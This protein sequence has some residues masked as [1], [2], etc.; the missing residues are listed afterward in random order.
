MLSKN[1]GFG[2]SPKRDKD[3]SL[4]TS[5]EREFQPYLEAR[6]PSQSYDFESFIKDRH[7][8]TSQHS[9]QPT[10][11]DSLKYSITN[12][13]IKHHYRLQDFFK[14]YMEHYLASNPAVQ[15]LTDQWFSQL[16]ETALAEQNSL[17]SKTHFGTEQQLEKLKRRIMASKPNSTFFSA[18][19][20]RSALKVTVAQTSDWHLLGV[21][22]AKFSNL[23]SS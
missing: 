12:F 13:S 22:I 3:D 11:D 23:L 16:F 5:V 6:G 9:K 15:D 4:G 8:T 14:P 20:T 1:E 21:V 18:L 17:F 19:M 7:S 2:T 10:N